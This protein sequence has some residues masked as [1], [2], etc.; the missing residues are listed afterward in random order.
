ML[1]MGDK[2]RIVIEGPVLAFSRLTS[3]VQNQLNSPLSN[4]SKFFPFFPYFELWHPFLSPLSSVPSQ[5]K[6]L[7]LR[8]HGKLAPTFKR[9]W[10]INDNCTAV[11]AKVC[12]GWHGLFVLRQAQI[13]QILSNWEIHR[14]MGLLTLLLDFF[15]KIIRKIQNASECLT[16]TYWRTLEILRTWRNDM[17]QK[18]YS[19]ESYQ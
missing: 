11:L 13:W 2:K 3:Q 14:N 18:T 19:T 1:R 4:C 7:K 12:E 15:A 5:W 9:T 16:L 10:H 8:K 6:L 17:R